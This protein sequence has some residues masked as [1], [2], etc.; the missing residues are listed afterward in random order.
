MNNHDYDYLI[1]GSG[2]GGSVSAHRLT[3]KGYKVGMIEKGQRL[4]TA[5]LPKSNWNLWKSIWAPIFGLHGILS[6]TLLKDVVIFH[7]SA[8][9]GGSIVYAN[10]H[11]EPL[12][13]FFTDPR[14]VHLSDDWKEE[15]G[16]YYA[17]AKRMLGSVESA[18]TY[19]IDHTLKEVLTD[20][21]TGDSFKKHTVGVFFGEA[22]VEVDDPYFGGDGPKRV[23]CNHCGSC[24]TGCRI[25]AKN[26]LD[27]NYLYFA[28]KYGTELHAETMVTDV[29]PLGNG[30]GSEGYEVLTKSS[31][32]RFFKKSRR[33]TAKN[34]VF[35]AGV[36]GTVKLLFGC[37]ESGSLPNISDALGTFVRTNSE[38]IQGVITGDK[39]V[40]K[41]VAISSGGFTPDGT[42]IEMVRYGEHADAM[43]AVTTVHTGG[44]KLP[45][46]LYWLAMMIRHPLQ[47]LRP[48]LWPFG[49][50]ARSAIVL[51][52]Q[53]VDNSMELRYQRRWWWPFKKTLNS[54]WG[55]R[56]AP[57]TFMPSAHEVALRLAEKTGGQ[58]ASV[59]PELALDT[60]TTAH[61]L[62]GCP[63]CESAED[64]VI[65]KYNRVHNYEGMYVVDAS[66]I[67]AN[68]GVNPSLTITALAERAMDHVEAKAGSGDDVS[69]LAEA[70]E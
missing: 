20:M 55:D 67:G 14:W 32:S 27:K 61:I 40:G 13:S 15:L 17:E 63:M 7:G 62:G 5:E 37:K 52:M 36:L 23:G 69:P 45:R 18:R 2:F 50:S 43:G 11:L 56:E 29:R 42:H 10:T 60:T 22:D 49:W 28:E 21:G 26:S 65:D 19:K 31:T 16:P 35:S 51:A 1:I 70:A 58:A 9:G 39:S 44:G 25:G 59:M 4:P 8:V 12:E 68:L 30:D 46:Q 24:M 3:Q 64:S 48:I 41:G 38:S 53:A 66:M 57:P 34:V 33:F 6:I 47:T 54:D